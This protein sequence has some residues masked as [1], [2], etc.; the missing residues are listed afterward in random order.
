MEYWIFVNG[1]VVNKKQFL[2]V[3]VIYRNF[4]VSGCVSVESYIVSMFVCTVRMLQPDT[5]VR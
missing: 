1:G 3:R 2:S 4:A 5:F